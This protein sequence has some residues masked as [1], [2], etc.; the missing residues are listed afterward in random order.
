[1][2]GVAKYASAENDVNYSVMRVTGMK[3]RSAMRKRKKKGEVDAYVRSTKMA[4]G[5]L[6]L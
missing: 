3:K 1:M 6:L 2:D 5:S 4:K